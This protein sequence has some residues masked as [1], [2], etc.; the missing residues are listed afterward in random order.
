MNPDMK[1]PVL[2][3]NGWQVIPGFISSTRRK[4]YKDRRIRIAAFMVNIGR[5]NTEVV[6]EVGSG[7]NGARKS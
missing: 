7:R 1:G 5:A 3:L 6:S 4:T 2:I